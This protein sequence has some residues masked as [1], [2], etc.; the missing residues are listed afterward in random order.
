MRAWT[1]V[2]RASASVAR[3]DIGSVDHRAGDHG[4]GPGGGD[5]L[6][7]PV[8]SRSPRGRGEGGVEAH[9]AAGGVEF[10]RGDPRGVERPL[11]RVGTEVDPLACPPLDR[12]GGRLTAAGVERCLRRGGLQSRE[13]QLG[14]RVAV[15]QCPEV[16]LIGRPGIATFDPLGFVVAG[17]DWPGP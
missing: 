17:M 4:A 10:G 8:R 6:R 15:E 11:E 7:D 12:S 2:S 13:A 5:D 3:G 9:G 14:Q 1:S 16:D